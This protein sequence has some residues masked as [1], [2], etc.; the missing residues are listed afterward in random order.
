VSVAQKNK[1]STM[2]SYNVQSI[3]LLMDC[4]ARRFWMME[5]LNSSLTSAQRSSAVK[6]WGITPDTHDEEDGKNCSQPKIMENFAY[7]DLT[8]NRFLLLQQVESHLT[9]FTKINSQ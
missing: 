5:Q 8:Q 4:T 1:P 3:D 7:P 6:W 9:Q 2:L